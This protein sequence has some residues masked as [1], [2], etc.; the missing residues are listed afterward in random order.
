M[1]IFIHGIIFEINQEV[2]L[3]C[4]ETFRQKVWFLMDVFFWKLSIFVAEI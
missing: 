3:K 4:H 1:P 2:N